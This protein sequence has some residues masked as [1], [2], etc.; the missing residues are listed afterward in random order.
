MK[1]GIRL[2]TSTS[3]K[4]FISGRIK[5]LDDGL[6]YFDQ[7]I[8]E[9]PLPSNDTFCHV[10]SSISKTRCYSDVIMLYKKMNLVGVKPDLYTFNILI[11]CCCQSGK[12]DYGFSLLGEILKRGYHPDTVTFTTL[13]KGLCLQGKID[14]ASKVCNKMTQ[15]GIQPNAMTCNS[16]IHGL[17]R[18]DQTHFAKEV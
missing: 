13:I 17:C 14:S 1:N 9:K 18:S 16:L 12:V 6:R 11:N 15:T 7:L 2:Q 3:Q 4:E 5:K 10:F 8:L